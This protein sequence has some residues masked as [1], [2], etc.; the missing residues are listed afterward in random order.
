MKRFDAIIIGAG[1]A[2]PPLAGRLTS[3]GMTV[4]FVE[5][6]QFGGTCINT[7]CRP[8]KT[9]VASARAAHVARRGSEFG[10]MLENIGIDPKRV[11]ARVDRIV[12]NGRKGVE[13][14]LAGMNGCTVFR[15]HARLE[16][17]TVVRVGAELL[18]SGHV[19][20][21]VGAR[22]LIPKLPHVAEVPYL[23]NSSILRLDT[24]PEHLVII[25]GS[26]V[27]LEFAQIYRRLGSK[28]TLVERMSRL[29][30]QEDEDVSRAVEE[31]LGSEGI[32]LRL[33]AECIAFQPSR[34]GVRVR[35]DCKDGSDLVV[36]SHVLLAVGR[37]P[38]TDDLGL[39]H[40]G[41]KRDERGYIIVDETLQTNV[42]S[43]WA[44]GECNGHGA[45][46]HTAYNDFEIAAANLLDHAR[47]RL[48]DR[49]PAYALY[50]D[51]PLGRVGTTEKALRAE[52][53]PYLVGRRPMTRVGRA[54]ERD[55]TQGFMK[56]LVDPETRAI[57]G[58]AILGIEG[59]EVIQAI[60]YFMYTRAPYATL[61]RSMGIHPT[62]AELVPTVLG[63]LAPG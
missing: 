61:A 54:I 52:G 2:G 40:A 32:A 48:A 3:A 27:G 5:R 6:G 63:E 23:T 34:D 62:V 15:G 12:E 33:E 19:F 56:I 20:L 1:Q 8:T 49:I 47:R 38:N 37:E 59:D 29:V 50:I 42:P 17:A 28:V 43:I 21:D 35:L 26:Y 25:G 24:I 53:R 18:Q 16:G 44:L 57:L 9:L 51:P 10:V 14:W 55:E 11:K 36:G 13:S 46:T 60:G 58:A 31:I 7:G 30:S 39:E 4:A 22:A 45:F 41:V